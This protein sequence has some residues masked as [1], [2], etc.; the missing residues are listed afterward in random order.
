MNN[1]EED[2]NT[3]DDNIINGNE[4]PIKKVKK[5]KVLHHK[6]DIK[7]TPEINPL[8]KN[9]QVMNLISNIM[10]PQ[11]IPTQHVVKQKAN[12]VD[13]IPQTMWNREK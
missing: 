1:D 6:Q 12:I 9:I 5:I 7:P 4:N 2:S 13:N 8:P 11:N 10:K 3:I